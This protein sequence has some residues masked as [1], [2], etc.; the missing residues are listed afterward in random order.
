MSRTGVKDGLIQEL[1]DTKQRMEQLQKE[2]EFQRSRAEKAEAE[3]N[4]LKMSLGKESDGR[5]IRFIKVESSESGSRLE[6]SKSLPER[7]SGFAAK[8]SPKTDNGKFTTPVSKKFS[9]SVLSF[10]RSNSE[11]PGSSEPGRGWEVQGKSCATRKQWRPEKEVTPVHSQR[12]SKQK[13]RREG[14]QNSEKL[15]KTSGEREASSSVYSSELV[16]WACSQGSAHKEEKK[17]TAGKNDG[18][19]RINAVR[20]NSEG[21]TSTYTWSCTLYV[22]PYSVMLTYIKDAQISV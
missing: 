18:G 8:A 3:L 2:V 7:S 14:L 22:L 12:S 17:I 9:S 6:K 13:R 4:E 11:P 10:F 16:H 5:S 1:K 19:R 20:S 15:S 21:T